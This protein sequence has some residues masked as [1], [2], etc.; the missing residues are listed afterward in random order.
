MFIVKNKDVPQKEKKRNDISEL[1]TV[2]ILVSQSVCVY[3]YTYVCF[4][5]N[6]PML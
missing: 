1:V 6:E 2:K 4:Y 5:K 3:I